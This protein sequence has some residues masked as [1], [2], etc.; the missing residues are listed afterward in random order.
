MHRHCP[1]L[2]RHA[3]SPAG[4][5]CDL[6]ALGKR[7]AGA[8]PD[9]LTPLEVIAWIAT[10]EAQF[11]SGIPEHLANV[12]E[13]LRT[14]RW[15]DLNLELQGSE[16]VKDQV[17][18]AYCKCGRP[19]KN[20]AAVRQWEALD[21]VQ[22]E[23]GRSRQDGDLYWLYRE[24][25]QRHCLC[26]ETAEAQLFRAAMSGAIVASGIRNGS[27]ETVCRTQWHGQRYDPSNGL[28]L[29]STGWEGVTLATNDVQAVWPADDISMSNSSSRGPGRPRACDAPYQIFLARRAGGVPL[30]P[31]CVAEFASCVD[32]AA[33]SGIGPLAKPKTYA[34]KYATEYKR[35]LAAEIYKSKSSL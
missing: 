11:V 15:M 26:F 29:L 6:V 3:M 23:L 16:A 1:A 4:A 12:T 18:R 32:E 35:A 10:R 27:Q 22:K 8:L 14:A 9:R 2:S 13:M 25:Q 21:D 24:A 5:D 28:I 31:S 7:R 17:A 20:R 19:F 33:R 34:Q 30:L